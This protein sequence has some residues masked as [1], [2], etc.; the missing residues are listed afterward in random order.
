MT[1]KLRTQA[2]VKHKGVVESV[3]ARLWT[4]AQISFREQLFSHAAL[5]VIGGGLQIYNCVDTNLCTRKRHD[6]CVSKGECQRYAPDCDWDRLKMVGK[7]CIGGTV[8]D[9]DEAKI[10][11][12]LRI[13]MQNCREVGL[14]LTEL[15]NREVGNDDRRKTGKRG[16]KGHLG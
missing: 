3:M 7:K 1:R 12:M 16:R 5:S 10:H 13:S 11:R 6:A 2:K 8:T 14:V 9:A 4:N 15:P